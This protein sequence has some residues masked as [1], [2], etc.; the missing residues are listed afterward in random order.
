[1]PPAVFQGSSLIKNVTDRNSGGVLSK[2]GNRRCSSSDNGCRSGSKLLQLFLWNFWWR[3]HC[4]LPTCTHDKPR[5]RMR[6][7]ECCIFKTKNVHINL[8]RLTRGSHFNSRWCK[9]INYLA[10]IVAFLCLYFV[11]QNILPNI[12]L[13]WNYISEHMC[14]CKGKDQSI[15]YL[16]N[17]SIVSMELRGNKRPIE[18]NS[19]S[20]CGQLQPGRS[21]WLR[22]RREERYLREKTEHLLKI[23]D[24]TLLKEIHGS[25]CV[26]WW[27]FG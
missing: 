9:L 7:R 20:R 27:V 24:F 14:V 11:T 4:W 6:N 15:T 10:F 8:R 23:S 2:G 22:S 19:R 21:R 12:P 18:C 13:I 17:Q 3:Q 25:R 16:I 5:H 26:C 1:M